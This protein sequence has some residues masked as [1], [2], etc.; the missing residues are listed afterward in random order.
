MIRRIALSG[1]LLAL[2]IPSAWA[3][4]V[5]GKWRV[6][7]ST[8]DGQINGFAAFTQTGDSVTGWVGPSESDPISI[9]VSLKGDKLTI[10]THPEPGRN[11]AFDKCEV[12]IHG[13]K[14]TGTIDVDKGTIEFVRS[15]P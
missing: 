12:T 2:A 9:S 15:A 5:S 3:A 7:I 14:M 10:Q 1:L 13:D 8:H 4:D 11:V 6:T